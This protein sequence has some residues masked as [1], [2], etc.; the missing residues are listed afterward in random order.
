MIGPRP[1]EQEAELFW[2][3]DLDDLVGGGAAALGGRHLLAADVQE[4]IGHV[5]RW[6]TLED[7]ARDR[8]APVARAAGRGQVLAVRFDGHAEERPLGGPLEI[9]RQLGGPAERADPAGCAAAR[10]P[11][12]VLLAA[13]E[14]DPLAVPVRHDRG[15]DL[16]AVRADDP[17][18]MPRLRVLD[19]GDP[20]VDVAD[21]RGLVEGGPDERVELARRVDVAHPVVA[22]RDDAEPGEC[23]DED[24]REVPGIALVAVARGIRDVGQR[25][26]HLAIDGVR[27]QERLG[28]HRVEVVDAVQQGRLDALGPQR[29]DDRVE[30]DRPAQAPDMDRA[31]RR[32]RVVDDLGAADR[33]R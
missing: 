30:D 24:A 25:T 27:G 29:P 19:V 31:G 9:P 16:A 3:D 11:L 7:L 32:L 8:V 14:V 12:D 10:G 6:F 21:E 28:V 4:L 15:A 2:R 17:D 5:E 1:Q 33:C 13:F 18:R 20:A 26:A 22:I 23:L